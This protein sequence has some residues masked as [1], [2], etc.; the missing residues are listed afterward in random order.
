MPLT[1]RTVHSK[2]YLRFRR[3]LYRGDPGYVY[4]EEFLVEMLLKQTTRFAQRCN[5]KPVCVFEDDRPVCQ[6]IFI[7]APA[8]CALQIA[9]FESLPGRDAAVSFLWQAAGDFAGE[10]GLTQIIAGLHGHLSYGVGIL[11]HGFYKNTFDSRYNKDYYQEYF[12]RGWSRETLTAYR[13]N[14]KDIR[15]I[16]RPRT[17]LLV[18]KIN[19]SRFERE[20]ETFRVLCDRTLGETG[21][22]APTEQGHFYELI[23][24]LRFFLRPENILFVCDG[25]KEVGFLFWYPD[26]NEVLAPG[27]PYSMPGIAMRYIKNRKRIKTIK[28]NAI[29]VLESYRNYAV[30]LLLYSL[31]QYAD[32]N[33][34]ILETGF[35]WDSNRPSSRLNAALFG[36]GARKYQVYFREAARHD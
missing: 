13:A 14:L 27:R 12:N 3:E 33:Y 20:M 15:K 29:G 28:V 31:Q 36:T 26:F 32:I 17:H 23:K 24:D 30:A 2:E 18:R 35:V 21:F 11:S 4:T 1:L 34:Q 19:L 8:P 7:I 9:Y 6:C 22:Y 25:D 16:P 5:I 10:N